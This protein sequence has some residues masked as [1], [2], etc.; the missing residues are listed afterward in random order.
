MFLPLCMGLEG[1]INFELSSVTFSFLFDL[2]ENLFHLY[3]IPGQQTLIHMRCFKDVGKKYLNQKKTLKEFLYR[4][5]HDGA[6]RKHHNFNSI[7]NLTSDNKK[8]LPLTLCPAGQW[9][10]PQIVSV[11]RGR[12]RA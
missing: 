7:S 1:L 3:V 11:V 4:Q 5:K 2:R 10:G 12:G 9:Q 6:V 8:F